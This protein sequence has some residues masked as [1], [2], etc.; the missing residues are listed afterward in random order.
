MPTPITSPSQ[1]DPNATYSY[2]DYLTWQFTEWVEL[3]KGKFQRP[4]AGAGQFHQ[5]VLGNLLSTIRPHLKGQPC[6]VIAAPFDVRL[7][8]GG[9]N[10]DDQILTVVQPDLV[11]VCDRAKL[12]ERGCLG[13]PDWII[14]IV[15]PGNTAR[16][17]R[18]KSTS[19]RKAAS[20]NTGSCIRASK[21]WRPSYCTATAMS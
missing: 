6:R 8:T 4:M 14:E 15:S 7:T 12:D 16:D 19:T 11:V 21:T 9:A 10:G 20:R 18:T 17:T 5:V 2:A 13:A 1:L 3:I